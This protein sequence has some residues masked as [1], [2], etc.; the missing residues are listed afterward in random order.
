MAER[1]RFHWLFGIL[2]AIAVLLVAWV[3]FRPGPAKPPAIH[4]VPVTVAKAAVQDVAV[5]IT[6][7]G[8]AQAWTSDTI[9]AQVSGKILSVNFVEGS[10]VQVGQVLAQIDPAPYRAVLTQAQGALMRDRAL[11][12]NARIDLAR[13]R[14]LLAANSIASQTVDTQAALVRQDEGT[15]LIDEGAVAAATVNLGW[16][17]IVSPIAGR[18]GVRLV[19]PGN[20]VSAGSSSSSA[21]S[22]SGTATGST[23][24]ATGGSSGSGIVIINQIKPIAVTFTVPE[25]DFQR[26]SDL[27]NGFRNPLATVALSQESGAVLDKGELSIAD[28][29]IDP[30]TGTVELKARF[31]NASETL[32][33][34]QFVNVQLTLQTLHNAVSIPL[35]AV[36][37]GPTGSFI[38]VIGK[39]NK[40]VMRPVELVWT[41]GATAV[42]KSGVQPGESVVID[43]QLILKAGS[44]VRIVQPA[45]ARQ[46]HA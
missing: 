32:W 42:I 3:I 17:R 5:T 7:I 24:A 10:D 41:E 20:I 19:D 39:G 30:S 14:A 26:L 18:A 25:G 46:A 8:A 38:Y 21:Q 9:Q 43:G 28:N 15:V 13:Y 37:R 36:N 44:A 31:P 33:P 34:G 35:A 4:P 11:L 12:A 16:C 1:R 40:A 22:T 29:R 6:A 45:Q 2:G 27:S 23:G